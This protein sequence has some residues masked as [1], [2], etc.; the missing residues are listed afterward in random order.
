MQIA[1]I[2]NNQPYAGR[3][4]KPDE[5]YYLPKYLPRTIK[6]VK[7]SEKTSTCLGAGR[8]DTWF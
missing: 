2:L 5:P 6:D 4:E 8:D 1:S 7:R 3:I